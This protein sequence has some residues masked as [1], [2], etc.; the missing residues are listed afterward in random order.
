MK[1]HI[2]RTHTSLILLREPSAWMKP[3]MIPRRRRMTLDFSIPSG[4]WGCL[5]I[6]SMTPLV[7]AMRFTIL[8]TPKHHE[9]LIG[10]TERI[11]APFTIWLLAFLPD[12]L[13]LGNAF[14]T[15]PSP[16]CGAELCDAPK[17]DSGLMTR[18]D[19]VTYS[20]SIFWESFLK[21]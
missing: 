11:H 5:P 10:T 1:Q 12:I 15:R 4:S 9:P 16:E 17:E 21:L 18:K 13:P 7:E 8:P 3:L 2:I 20:S 6:S 14:P 19:W